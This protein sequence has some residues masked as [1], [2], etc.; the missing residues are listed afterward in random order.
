MPATFWLIYHIFSDPEVLDD[1]RKELWRAVKT[2]DGINTIDTTYVK[3]QCPIFLSTLQETFRVHSTSVASRVVLEDHILDGQY[4]LKK[5]GIVLI[6]AS[7]QH[8]LDSAWG[9]DAANF[10]HKRFLQRSRGKRYN[11]VAFRAF[12]GGSTLCP[13]R[14]FVTTE[15][16]A[17]AA[18]VTL[19]FDVNPRSGSWV[20]P[21]VASSNPATSI[22]QPDQDIQVDIWPRDSHNWVVNLSESNKKMEIS[23]EDMTT[24]N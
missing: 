11:P 17:F 5:G 7:V 16:L 24:E 3:N 4:L 19:R 12:G 21:T 23:V 1:C 20:V 8:N 15:I 9:S 22:D 10:D 13:G 2:N 18:L 6:P 14:H